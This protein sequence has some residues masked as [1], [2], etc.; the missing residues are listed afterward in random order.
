[1]PRRLSLAAAALLAASAVVWAAPPVTAAT[2]RTPPCTSLGG[3]CWSPTSSTV[4]AAAGIP[5]R[6]PLDP[7]GT[8]SVPTGTVVVPPSCPTTQW[9]GEPVNVVARAAVWTSPTGQ[10]GLIHIPPGQERVTVGPWPLGEYSVV[11]EYSRTRTA[12]HPCTYS[13][14]VAQGFVGVPIA[15]PSPTAKTPGVA[16]ALKGLRAKV[17]K[18]LIGGH[19]ETAPPLH[20]LVWLPT[21]VWI[22]GANLPAQGLADTLG[23]D[24]K[25]VLGPPEAGG[26]RLVL[27]VALSL[28]RAGVVWCWGEVGGCQFVASPGS[29]GQPFVYPGTG[30]LSHTYYQVSV[31]GARVSPY[32]VVNPQDE[33]PISARQILVARAWVVWTDAFGRHVAPLGSLQLSLSAGPHWIVIGQVEGVPYCPSTTSCG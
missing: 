10:T 11:M 27:T 15:F 16:A 19:V 23:T 12:R 25:T 7:P 4:S 18:H 9:V 3:T 14:W 32:P 29:I 21:F 20:A 28:V 17:L 31:H 6:P 13:L 2:K 33:I 22:A 5:G 30:G 24:T 1:M 26:R 8:R